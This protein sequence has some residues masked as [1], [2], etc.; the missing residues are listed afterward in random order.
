MLHTS[1]AARQ[2]VHGADGAEIT[3]SLADDVL[4]IHYSAPAPVALDL[5][6][7]IFIAMDLGDSEGSAVLPFAEKLEGSTVFLPFRANRFYALP[8]GAKADK[9]WRRT[10]EKWKW[11]DRLDTSRE[12]VAQGA[13]N[14]LMVRFPIEE[15]GTAGKIKVVIYSKDFTQ[16]SWGRLF[17]CNDPAVYGG[18]GDQ[19]IPYYLEVDVRASSAPRVRRRGR[20]EAESGRLRI[21]Q[22][23]VRLFSNLNETRKPNGTLAENG[24]GKFNH[25]N[26]AALESLRQMGFTHLWLTGIVQQATGTDY[27][28][29]GRPADDPDLLKGVAGSPYAIKDYFDVS[30]DYAEK[31][32]KRI[33]EFQALLE[34]MRRH[35]LKA[36]IDFVPNH[37]ARSYQSSV[38]PEF[39]F[40][41]KGQDGKGDDTS[42]FFDP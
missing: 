10:W 39:D 21:Y 6:R 14:K 28:S 4:Q 36:L 22:L 33:E 18:T 7:T 13:A 25:I 9:E 34:R 8:T 24:V 37:V 40:G 42:R 5:K 12:L 31:A 19:Y 23:F 26:D 30:P 2:T 32:E 41:V 29:I 38:K 11:S 27:A 35:E 20:L 15:L 17:G 1:H 3:F 16:E